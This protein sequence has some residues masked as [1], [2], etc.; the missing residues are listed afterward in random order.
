MEVRT[1]VSRS[2][3]FEKQLAKVPDFIRKKVVLWVFLVESNGVWEVMKTP[4][5]H[6]E[7]LKGERK[8][9]RSVRL[10]IAYRLIYRVV[11]DRVHIELLEVHKHDY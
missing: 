4:G 8:T 11:S 3:F 5:F 9:Q 10:N 6:D 1:R 7:P 2:R